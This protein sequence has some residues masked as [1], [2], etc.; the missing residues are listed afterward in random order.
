[1]DQK[2]S[3]A[4][5]LRC[6]ELILERILLRVLICHVCVM[7]ARVELQIFDDICVHSKFF[8]NVS[9]LAASEDVSP[10]FASICFI[11]ANFHC[12]RSIRHGLRWLI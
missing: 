3:I 7:H 2:L 11:L 8:L 6:F 10:P 1:M 9:F 5:V 12:F 4:A